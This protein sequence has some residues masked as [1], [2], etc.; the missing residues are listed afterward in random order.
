MTRYLQH[1]LFW[2]FL[3]IAAEP[4]F[5]ADKY[6][7]AAMSLKTGAALLIVV[8]LIFVLYALAA[9]KIM[10]RRNTGRYIEIIEIRHV[11]HKNSLA[12]VKVRDTEL[13][14][15]ISPAGIRALTELNGST[16]QQDFAELLDRNQ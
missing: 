6:G 7:L 3:L 4:A 16:D 12:L 15:S 1:I 5:C 8:G 2:S 11:M 9:K 14:L 10:P 13:L